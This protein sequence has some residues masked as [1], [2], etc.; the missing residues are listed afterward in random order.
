M[1]TCRLLDYH[2]AQSRLFH[3]RVG[4]RAMAHP[5]PAEMVCHALAFLCPMIMAFLA[6]RDG[7]R[8]LRVSLYPVG[9]VS[10]VLSILITGQERAKARSEGGESCF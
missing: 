2:H 3:E 7:T 5:R 1:A 6:Q 8:N 4:T 9:V 10:A